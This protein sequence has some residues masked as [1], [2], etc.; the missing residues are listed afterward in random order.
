[1]DDTICDFTSAYRL[2]RS[3]NPGI[4]FPQSQYGF[5]RKLHPIPGAA[6]FMEAMSVEHDVWIATRPSVLNPLCYSEK[7]EW[8]EKHLGEHWCHKLIIIPDKSLLKGDLLIDDQP[9]PTFEGKQIL[10]GKAP[11]ETWREVHTAILSDKIA[12]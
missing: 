10:F 5:F 8:V 3:Q 6:W 7:R 12:F 9:W 11:Y 2:A 4:A 1:M